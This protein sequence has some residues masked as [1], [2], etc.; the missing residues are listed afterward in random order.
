MRTRLK[1]AIMSQQ[2]QKRIN[3]NKVFIKMI[4]IMT[5]QTTT[6][7]RDKI[8]SSKIKKRHSKIFLNWFLIKRSQKKKKFLRKNKNL[9]LTRKLI[10]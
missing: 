10:K 2:N 9:K 3:F 4:T 1:I 8:S 7:K 6:K 5:N